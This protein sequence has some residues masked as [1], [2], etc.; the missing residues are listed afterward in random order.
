[1]RVLAVSDVVNSNLY[2]TRVREMAGNVDAIISCGDLP[3]YYLDYLASSLL[4]PL[5]YVCGNHDHYEA[6]EDTG[7]EFLK[8]GIF[9]DIRNGSRKKHISFGGRNLDDRVE[10]IGPVL[11]GGLEGSLLYNRGEHQYTERQMS[12][13]IL[14]IVPVM[15]M[16]KMVAGRFLDVLITH[17]PP[18][19]IHDKKDPAHK[20]F[21]S[22]ISF[23]KRYRPKYLLHGHTHIYDMT[24]K[25][26]FEYEGT[27]VINCYDFVIL[28][29][30]V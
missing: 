12:R 20:G 15:L 29:I 13:K 21:K 16:N 14:K 28:D 25:R 23:I 10:K 26:I 8:S 1:M 11:V 24:E 4:K 17:A 6:Q 19:G 7:E 27:K 3:V 2:S 5:Y 18:F 30:K 9:G 22:L